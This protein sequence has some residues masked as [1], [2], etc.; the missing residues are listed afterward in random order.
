MK[1]FAVCLL[2]YS[3]LLV[4]EILAAQQHVLDLT[5]PDLVRTMPPVE[6]GCAIGFEGEKPVRVPLELMLISLDRQDYV[7]GDHVTYQVNLR[8]VGNV[9]LSLPW[10]VDRAVVERDRAPF[11]QAILS[12]AVSDAQKREHSLAA[13]VLDGSS[14]LPGSIEVLAP[15]ETASILVRSSLLVTQGAASSTLAAG[16][17][18]VTV[19]AVLMMT[20][21]PCVWAEKV[22]STNDVPILFR[23]PRRR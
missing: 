10:S 14:S 15:G 16:V 4:G 8:N 6:S 18:P 23:L 1:T 9:P 17:G 20:V 12:L 13:V 2:A 3:L 21:R 19:G 7:L 11:S 5:Q 22:F